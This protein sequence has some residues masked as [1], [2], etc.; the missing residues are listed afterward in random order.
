[1]HLVRSAVRPLD[2]VSAR[3]LAGVLLYDDTVSGPRFRRFD[4]RDWQRAESIIAQRREQVQR[5]L[6]ELRKK[7]ALA[8]LA[9]KRQTT[10]DE[11][12]FQ[13]EF[14]GAELV[15]W[16]EDGEGVRVTWEFDGYEHSATMN[17]EMKLETAGICLGHG[18][19]AYDWQNLSTLVDTIQEARRLG[20][21]DIPREAWL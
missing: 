7:A 18:P 19:G 1:M 6:V 20:R 2:V 10:E 21:G 9:A 3:D 16:S 13:L 12:K 14:M 8:Q 5:E 4:N 17:R 11:I 15:D